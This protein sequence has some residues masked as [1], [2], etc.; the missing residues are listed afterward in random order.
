MFFKVILEEI[1]S[2]FVKIVRQTH[3]EGM[4]YIFI[5]LIITFLGFLISS[6]LGFILLLVS[7]WCIYFFRDP[8]RVTQEDENIISSPADGMIV[9]IS[10]HVPPVET[11]INEE[12]HKVSI[13]LSV[14]NVHVNRIPI[15][16]RVEKVIYHKGKFLNASVDKASEE[17]ERNTVVLETNHGNVAL[18]QIAGL[19]ARRIICSVSAGKEVNAGERYGIIKFGSRVDIYFPLTFE[20]KVLNGQTVVGGETI[21][22]E[23]STSEND[24]MGE[25]EPEEGESNIS[26]S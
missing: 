11:G 21:I 22:A 3:S 16:G 24:V 2:F 15:S 8:E 25:F 1:K 13:F 19:I 18:V 5:S 26:S 6:K 17:N 14:F 12:M 4:I 9:D 10:R 23:K 7:F 20:I